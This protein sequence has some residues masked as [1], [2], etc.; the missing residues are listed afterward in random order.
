M[1]LKYL[2]KGLFGYKKASVYQYIAAMEEEIS[3][4]WREEQAQAKQNAEAYLLRIGQL[5]T[6]LKETKQQ[7]EEQKNEQITIASTLLDAK[8]YAEALKRETQEAEQAAR[9]QLE[10]EIASAKRELAQYHAQIQHLRETFRSLLAGMED[11]AQALEQNIQT[12]EAA[13]PESNMSL[14]RR[15]STPAE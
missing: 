15:R 8:R 11:E 14:F 13:C 7:L 1:E 2:K 6:E 10:E 4:K 9:R 5:E 12:A 3:S